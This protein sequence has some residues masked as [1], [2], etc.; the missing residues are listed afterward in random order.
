MK[1]LVFILVSVLVSSASAQEFGFVGGVHSGKGEDPNGNLTED[2]VFS[3]RVGLGIKMDLTDTVNLRTGLMYVDR[4]T[5]YS[6]STA[7]I[8][9]NFAYLDI[10]VLFEI[11]ANEM[12]GF[13]AGPV[14]AF[15]MN[16]NGKVSDP[17]NLLGLGTSVDRDV[18]DVE[19]MYLLAQVGMS[20]NFDMIGF[21]LFYERG[22]GEFVKDD[23]EN[24]SAFGA[25][26]V[27]WF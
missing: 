5:E 10:P 17:S 7:D 14:V 4:S 3:Y 1:K 20:F 19:S 21:E 16:E 13:F 26:F 11:K 2:S 23:A 15:N 12:I 8:E 25:N 24:F 27:Y 6:F 9:Y 22:L 18:D